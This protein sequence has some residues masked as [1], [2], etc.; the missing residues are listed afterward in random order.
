MILVSLILTLLAN[1]IAR[2]WRQPNEWRRSRKIAM[3]VIV[4]SEQNT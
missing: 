1:L 2:L 4:C 3:A